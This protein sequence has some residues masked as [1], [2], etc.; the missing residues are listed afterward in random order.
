MQISIMLTIYFLFLLAYA[1]FMAFAFYKVFLFA[2][3]KD[4]KGYSRRISLVILMLALTVVLITLVII[5][6]Y[7]WDDSVGILFQNVTTIGG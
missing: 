7:Q 4:L 2:Q 3:N 5:Q 6:R 1:G